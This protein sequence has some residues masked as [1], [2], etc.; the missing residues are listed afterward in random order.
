MS[1]KN[2]YIAHI[3]NNG[4]IQ[5]VREHNLGV[6]ALASSY[7]IS[8]MEKVAAEEGLNHDIGKYRPS[9][10]K[11]IRGE[12]NRVEH[13]ICGAMAMI[14]KYG[15]NPLSILL[16]LS[17]AGHHGGIPDCGSL[18][19]IPDMPTLF[20]RLK[21]TCEDYSAYL[22]E[23]PEITDLD[24]ND[25][26]NF[27]LQHCKTKEEV[28]DC[29]AFL[30]RYCYSCLV[31][32]DSI[33]TMQAETGS[34]PQSLTA[35]FEECLEKLK[36]RI[37]LLKQETEL[38]KARMQIQMQAISNIRQD[39]DAYLLATPAG[40]GKTFTGTYCALEKALEKGIKRI[41]YIIP[42]NSII[43]Q[44]ASDLE[45]MFGDSAEILRHQST[46]LYEDQ[47][48][49]D[50]DLKS[51][52]IAACENWDAQIIITTGVQ[53]FESVCS[54]KRSKLR[55]MHNIANSVLIFDEAHMMPVEYLQPCLS[56]V[57]F[58]TK[59]LNSK[60][61]F[62][63]ATMPDFERMIKKNALASCKIQDLVPDHTHFDRFKKNKYVHIGQVTAK[64]LLRMATD[65]PSALVVV[66]KKKT[67]KR[68][69]KKCKG[70]KY[71]LSTWMSSEDISRV[72]QEVKFELKRLEEDFP[73]L[74]NVPPE[75]RITLISTSL[76]EAGVNLD[77][78][79]VFRELAGLD[80]VIQSGG[81]CNRE[82]FFEFGYVYVFELPDTTGKMSIEQNILLS[83][84]KEYDDISSE[85]AIRTYYDRLFAAKKDSI[86]KHSL[87]AMCPSCRYDE[88][89]FKTYS[90]EIKLIES[91]T[92]SIVIPSDNKVKEEINTAAE[93][94]CINARKLQPYCCS[95]YENELNELLQQGAVKEVAGIHVLVNPD[96]Y[97][98]ATG[99]STEGKDFYI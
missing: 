34:I 99:I 82:G 51:A 93:T 1:I 20:G 70:K 54:N 38:Q 41:I 46:F 26:N 39:A 90:E 72:I 43:N 40:S 44:V 60:A 14:K 18:Y 75:R 33:D 28:L 62:M 15:H 96:Y 77:F 64:E 23:Q 5:T 45:E 98:P 2:K 92:I 87:A 25:F 81:R 8:A 85:E 56:A 57:A 66:N 22:N 84:I 17:I 79:A 86:A 49:M 58:A 30:V 27:L 16:A 7:A 6:S 32:A 3:K 13:S 35:D 9:F 89:P 29:Y 63:T 11:R 48:N 94:G 36:T 69:F 68:L 50:E 73:G 55:K 21:R 80:N 97:D 91:K 74:E 4:G 19:D 53:F 65:N 24:P 12:N 47:E 52:S 71:H 78:F 10:Q 67:A 88:I 59:Y 61:I 31:D 83:I 37:A 42:R 76:I 95:V